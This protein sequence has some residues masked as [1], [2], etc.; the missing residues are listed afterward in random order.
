MADENEAVDDAHL[1]VIDGLMDLLWNRA[2]ENPS[3][4]TSQKLHA[5]D[6][7]LA[8]KYRL[9]KETH[10]AVLQIRAELAAGKNKKRGLWNAFWHGLG[11]IKSEGDKIFKE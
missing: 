5:V 2:K 9:Q 6:P 1:G 3:L 7:V 8:E 4:T 11:I 10:D